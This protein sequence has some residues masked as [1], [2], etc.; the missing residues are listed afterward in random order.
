[1]PFPPPDYEPILNQVIAKRYFP[2][3]ILGENFQLTSCK[4]DDYNCIAW[5]LGIDDEWK[6][7]Y[8]NNLGVRDCNKYIELFKES[9]FIVIENSNFEEGILKI[10]IFYEASTNHFKHV[11]RQ[12]N[13]NSWTSKLGEWED[14]QHN[15]PEDLLGDSYGDTLIFMC[16][17]NDTAMPST[18]DCPTE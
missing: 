4:T 15:T 6:Q 14:I 3:L 13:N 18:K 5:S 17:P 1:M 12:I 7:V 2:K 16:K 11:A 9:G 8:E 10:A